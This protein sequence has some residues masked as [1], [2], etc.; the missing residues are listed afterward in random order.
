MLE[1]PRVTVQDRG[2]V[3]SDTTVCIP[4]V[5]CLAE[6]KAVW[7]DIGLNKETAPRQ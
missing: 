6:H 1:T 7:A 4:V 2:D 5:L 3:V